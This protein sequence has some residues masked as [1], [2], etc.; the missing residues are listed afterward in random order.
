METIQSADL[1]YKDEASDKEYHAYLEKCEDEFSKEMDD[2]YSVKVAY[3]RR[4]GAMQEGYKVERV[5][6][7]EAKKVFD[8]AVKEKVGKGYA[9]LGGSAP[10]V[11]AVVRNAFKPMLCQ[12]ATLEEAKKRVEDGEWVVEEK[13]DGIRAYIEGGKLYDRHGKEITAKFPEF[14]GLS[15]ITAILD[16]EVL[17]EEF[18]QVQSRMHTKDVFMRKLLSKKHPAVFM[19]FD[20]VERGQPLWARLERLMKFDGVQPWIRVVQGGK[21]VD[22]RWNEIKEDGREGIVVKD[23]NSTYQEGVRSP[24]WLKVKTFVETTAVFVKLDVHPR[25][26]RLETADGKSVNVNGAQAEE[27]KEKFKK[28]GKVTCDVQYLPQKDSEA[29]RFPSFRGL[30]V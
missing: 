21:E 14:A 11:Q 29:W 19:V 10:M 22:A 25:G 2:A 20:C 16:G 17:C 9:M 15:E 28:D 13:Y 12:P 3:G 18:S 7:A 1:F 6:L 23:L 27:V 24:S 4:D 30:V 5:S 26:V 8:K